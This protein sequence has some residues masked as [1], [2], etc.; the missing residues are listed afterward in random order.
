MKIMQLISG[1]ACTVLSVGPLN[2]GV[3]SLFS[4]YRPF[5]SLV[6]SLDLLLKIVYKCTK[7]KTYKGNEL[8]CNTIIKILTIFNIVILLY[9][10][11]K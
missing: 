1:N 4:C 9:L 7:Y 2:S 3:F 11:I 6:K 8:C 10:Q 5:G